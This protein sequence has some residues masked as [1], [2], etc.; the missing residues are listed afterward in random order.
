MPLRDR[1]P[2]VDGV[3]ASI[4]F[5]PDPNYSAAGASNAFHGAP[6]RRV[7]KPHAI[8]WLQTIFR[9]AGHTMM[10]DHVRAQ[11]TDRP[12]SEQKKA[13]IK[14]AAPIAAVRRFMPAPAYAGR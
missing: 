14:T 13:P 3:L 5:Y 4:G 12:K 10:A 2:F 6:F 11:Y 7:P 8:A 9:H 1:V